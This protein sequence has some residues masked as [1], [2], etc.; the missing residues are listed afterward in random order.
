MQQ[1]RF[2]IYFSV[3]FREAA[4]KP[5]NIVVILGNGLQISL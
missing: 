1:L 5:P 4:A 3:V 2:L